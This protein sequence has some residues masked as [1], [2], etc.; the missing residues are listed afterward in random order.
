MVVAMMYTILADI[1][2]AA[3]RADAFFRIT[4]I[5]LVSAMIAGPLAGAIMV[6]SD[7]VA[8]ILS[9]A[10]LL[11]CFPVGMVLPETLGL[12]G[13]RRRR[14]RVPRETAD[15]SDADDED[16]EDTVP[17]G[18]SPALQQLWRN[19][20]ESLGE[21]RGFVFGNKRLVFLMMSVI[22]VILG[23]FVQEMLMQY[24]TKR[25]GWSWSKATLLLTIRSAATLA[26]LLALLPF[27]S[28]F[29]MT[30]LGMSGI[31]KDI[32]LARI[33]GLLSIVGALV[34]AAA[35]NGYIL[36][37]GLVWLSL[38]GG[39]S[40]LT[41]SLLNSLVEE[42]HLGVVNSLVA[43]MEMTGLMMAGPVLAKSLSIGMQWG[44]PWIGLPF[45][46]AAGFLAIATAILFVFRPSPGRRGP[47]Q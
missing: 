41:R 13:P 44:G 9:L 3:E 10:V 7:W 47:Q 43:F 33:S 42:H 28:W 40:Q 24:A 18:K 37:V 20:Q 38:G 23:K 29:C 19:A 21:V 14:L 36:S 8:L 4:A 5:Y 46:I 22:F 31:T 30:R 12:H 11:L 45:L 2:P 26:T 35:V 32:W 34:I 15:G 6:K 1:I 16:E 17:D 27:A 39:I 25:Y